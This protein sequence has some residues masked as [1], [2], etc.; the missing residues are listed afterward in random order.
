[1]AAFLGGETVAGGKMKTT[2]TESWSSPNTGATNSSEFTALYSSFRGKGGFI[3]SSNGLYYFGAAQR[4]TMWMP[5]RGI[6]DSTGTI[7]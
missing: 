5:G 3:P 1:M 4:M 6:C 2:G 7:G